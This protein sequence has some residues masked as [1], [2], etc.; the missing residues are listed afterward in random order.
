MLTELVG[1]GLAPRSAVFLR[2]VIWGAEYQS[3]C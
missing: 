2:L 3:E 1:V